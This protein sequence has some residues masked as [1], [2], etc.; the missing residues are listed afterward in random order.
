MAPSQVVI[1]LDVGTTGV[2]AAAFGLGEPWHRVAMREYPLLQPAPGQQVQD[3]RTIL[4]STADALAE[5]VEATGPAE[6][7]AV[8]LGAGMHGLVA[9]GADRRPVTPLV[10]WADA[11]S[12]AEARELHRA[13]QAAALHARTGVPVH[14]MTPLTKLLWFRRHDPATW[15]RARWWGGLKDLLVGWLTGAPA[16]EL[17]SASGTGMLDVAT[18]TWSTLALD[19]CGLSADDLTP[20]EAP[21]AVLALAPAAADRIGLPAGTPV[22]AGAADGPLGNLGTGALDPGVAGLSLGTSGAVRM[23]VDGPRADPERG[24]FCFALTEAVWVVGGAISNGAA[25]LRWAGSTFAGDARVAAGDEGPDAAVL[26]LAAKAPAGSDG[27]VMLPYLLAERAPLWDPDLPGAYIGLR[28]EHTREH[29]LRAAVEGVCMQLRLV[30]DELDAVATV[31]SVRATG[32][33][34]RSRLWRE[35]MAAVLGRPLVV[36]DGVD[37]TARGAAALGLLALGRAPTLGEAVAQLAGSTSPPPSPVVV[38]SALVATY[39]RLRGSVA[40]LIERLGPVA[41]LFGGR[42]GDAGA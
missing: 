41:G 9:F 13:G 42:G 22:V 35:V 36:V 12:R 32:G 34:F 11:R 2:K 39:D 7:V 18:R 38:D 4:A 25:A 19:L 30:L 8:S 16:T 3:P 24:L 20:I 33:A 27:L 21:T 23:A 17:S 29:L 40:G 14:P 28:P 6:V 37:G 10:T 1:G 5:C 31:T 15:Q 26:E